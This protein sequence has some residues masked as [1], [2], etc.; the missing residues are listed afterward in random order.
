MD[1]NRKQI[2]LRAVSAITELLVLVLA[3][4]RFIMT[5]VVSF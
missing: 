5:T 1:V 2:E 4:A 3:Y